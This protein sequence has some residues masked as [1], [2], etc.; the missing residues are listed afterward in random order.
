MGL[1]KQRASEQ[2]W[3]PSPKCTREEGSNSERYRHPQRY[4]QNL[5]CGQIQP[6]RPGVLG[7]RKGTGAAIR[8]HDTHHIY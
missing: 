7:I 4:Q 1:R 2:T 5:G 6:G 8:F 3:I